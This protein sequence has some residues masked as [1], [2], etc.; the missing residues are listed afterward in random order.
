M[1]YLVPLWYFLI[2]ALDL[3]VKLKYI[4]FWGEINVQDKK[5]IENN[6]SILVYIYNENN[7]SIRLWS[8][9]DLGSALLLFFLF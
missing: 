2:Y 9:Y 5:V 8:D 6:F 3:F 1:L 4:P 7:H